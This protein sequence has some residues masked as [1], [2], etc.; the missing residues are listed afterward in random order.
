M[1][2]FFNTNVSSYNIEKIN[3]QNFL[4]LYTKFIIRS[5]NKYKLN[6]IDENNKIVTAGIQTNTPKG[7]S[8]VLQKQNFCNIYYRNLKFTWL[9]KKTGI[10]PDLKKI[11]ENLSHIT[12]LLILSSNKRGFLVYT[13]GFKGFL[14]VRD[15]IQILTQIYNKLKTNVFNLLI[16]IN[17]RK[18]SSKYILIRLPCQI[19]SY[20]LHSIQPKNNF[21]RLNR[22][23]ILKNKINLKFTLNT[24]TK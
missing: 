22:K 10:M 6:I 20:I 1:T 12:S 8:I 3:K 2:T 17:K 21:S 23:N 13:N 14:K 15:L 24:K 11:S 7:C 19:K 9:Q 5:K 16:E 18:Y 4:L